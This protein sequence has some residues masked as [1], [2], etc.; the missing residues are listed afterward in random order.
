MKRGQTLAA[1]LIVLVIM[2]ILAVVLF[3]GSGAFSGEKPKSSR[4]DGHGTT[5]LGAAEYAARD[6]VC[7]SNLGQVRA[8]LVIA[9][10]SNEDTP[11]TDL[12]ETKLPAEFYSCPIG[13]EP[14]AY[15]PAT[16]VVH[17]V[18]P[19]HEKY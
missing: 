7:R 11:P 5:V 13:K 16:G 8:A 17:C 12:K 9:T 18:H 4:P 6:D 19:G 10:Q 1:T 3:R 15:D 14:Y 2:A